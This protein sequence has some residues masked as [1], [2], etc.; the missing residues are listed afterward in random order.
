MAVNARNYRGVGIRDKR[1]R[2]LSG[3]AARALVGDVKRSSEE[4]ANGA[5][6]SG[7]ASAIKVR[8]P[9]GKMVR[10]QIDT[11]KK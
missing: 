6:V 5:A 9:D 7:A 10:L 2:K 8:Y 4:I 11:V 1:L 3:E